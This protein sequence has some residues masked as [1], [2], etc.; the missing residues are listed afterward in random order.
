MTFEETCIH[1]TRGKPGKDAEDEDEDTVAEDV[2]DY[3]ADE[4]GFDGL[5]SHDETFNDV[6]RMGVRFGFRFRGSV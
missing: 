1:P 2:E 5:G 4:D 3:E 6:K